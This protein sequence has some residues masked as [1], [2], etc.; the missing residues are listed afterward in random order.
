MTTRF[1][2]YRLDLAAWLKSSGNLHL[3]CIEHEGD[4]AVFVFN[5]P[6]AKGEELE[7]QYEDSPFAAFY[8][9]VK[10]LRRQMD[11]DRNREWRVKNGQYANSR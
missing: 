3:D 8:C 1:Q 6:A 2:T 9:T 10:S 7:L 5:D 4:R 11:A